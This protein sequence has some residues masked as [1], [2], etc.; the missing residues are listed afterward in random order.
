MQ[1]CARAH[2]YTYIYKFQLE[3]QIKPVHTYFVTVQI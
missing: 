3:N 2:R 1:I